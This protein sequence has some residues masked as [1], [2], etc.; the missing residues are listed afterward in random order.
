MTDFKI[1]TNRLGEKHITNEGYE[2][3]II[4]YFNCKNCTVIFE[5]GCEIKNRS[6]SDLK[7]GKIKNPYHLSVYGVGCLGEGV[8][9]CTVNKKLTSEYKHWKLMLLRCYNKKCQ[10]RKLTYKNCLVD[11]SWHNFQNFAQ[12]YEENYKLYMDT[13]WHL[14]KDIMVK[15]NKIY[16]ANTCC[17]VPGEINSLFVKNNKSR[18]DYPIGVSKHKGRIRA[19]IK[20]K[21]ESIHLGNFDTEEEAFQACK[22][23]KEAH[24]KE[25]AEEWKDKVE[26]KVYQAMYNWVVEI[27]D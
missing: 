5:N 12:W 27:T 8:Y 10:D 26:D 16:S 22:I 7:K 11:E 24:I 19:T 25:K 14:D 20:I 4:E 3:E 2:V 21:N 17:L 13:N 9:K 15:G 23:A 18:G 1:S 6:Y